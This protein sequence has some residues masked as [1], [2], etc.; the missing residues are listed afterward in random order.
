[1]IRRQTASAGGIAS[2]LR[3]FEDQFDR[4]GP[5]GAGHRR[6]KDLTKPPSVPGVVMNDLL[7]IL[8]GTSV[9][10]NMDSDLSFNLTNL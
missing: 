9:L 3:T 2:L 7:I 1:M 10:P 8:G 6:R 5:T 4:G